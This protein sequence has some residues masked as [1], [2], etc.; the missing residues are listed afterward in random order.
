MNLRKIWLVAA[1]MVALLL[2]VSGAPSSQASAT[3]SSAPGGYFV[4]IP[5]AQVPT[6]ARLGLNPLVAVE[7]GS[8][9]WLELN[10]ADY[11]RLAS[12]GVAFT[13]VPDA[14]QV[15][16]VAYT[17]DPITDGEPTLDAGQRATTTGPALRLV[18]FVGPA[19]DVWLDAMTAAGL[20]VLQ[21]YPSNAFLTWATEA[22]AAAFAN[23]SFVRWQGVIHP[24]YK[25]DPAL[26]QM[27]GLI[28]NVDVM[29]YN[30]GRLEATLDAIT[31]LGGQILQS[32]PS[33]PDKAFYNAVV[34]LPAEAVT[35]VTQLNTVLWLGHLSPTPILDDEM[36][37]QIQ[38]GNH[39]GGTPVTGYTAHLSNLGVTGAGVVWAIVDTGVDYDHPDLG[40]NI[41][42][43]Y[44]FPGACSFAGQPGSDCAGGGHGTHVAG[45]VGGTAAAGFADANGFLYGLGVAPGYSIFAMNSL[46]A[47]AWPPA[48]GWQEHSKRAVLGGAIGGNN[49]WTTGEGTNHGYQ[50]SERTHDI[51]VLDGNFDTA[52]VAEPFIE[53]FS[54]GNSGPGANTLT[55]PKEAKNLIITASSVNFR[56]GNI[57]TISSF[58]SRGPA[59]D[60]RWVP[61]I[62]APGEQ[63]ASAR[64]DLGGSC[65]TAIPGTNNLY[66]FCSGTSM[67]SPHAAGAVVLVTEWWR[68][69]NAGADPSP[70]M[71]KALLVNGA[72]DMGTADIPNANEGWGRVN[73]TN[74]IS[75]TAMVIYFDQP[76]IFSNTG[77]QWS[78]DVGVPDPSQPL[79]IT[80]AWSDAPGAVGANPALVNNLN[81]SVVN[82]A[83]TY[84]G[85]V[86][87]GGWSATGGAADTRNNLENVYVQNPAGSA[88]ITI[89]AANI[90]GDAILYNGDPTDQSFALVCSNCALGTDF[91]L[92]A[93]PSSQNVC[94][95][96]DAVY[97]VSVGSIL[98]FVDPVALSASGNP[99]G[100]TTGFSVNPVTPPGNSVLTIGNTGAAVAGSYAIDVVGVA[101]TSTH[102]TTVQLNLFTNA[103]A[104]PS[105]TAPGNGTIN[106]GCPTFTWSDAGATSYLL[107]VDTD[108]NF[109]NIVYTANV[110]GTSHTAG[111]TLNTS[112]TYLARPGQQHLWQRQLLG[113][114]LLHHRCRAR[115]LRSRQRRQRSLRLWL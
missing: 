49:S 7:Y 107:E 87:S 73:V 50:A 110:N 48:G 101:P 40:P 22:E 103:P 20:P 114:L 26:A 38:A 115:R 1:I 43:G 59:A 34:K 82:G 111:A 42:G 57:N 62:T 35:A 100:T 6:A 80:L 95:P 55:A 63:I 36:S 52:N 89:N 92:T 41:V 67:A 12:S 75:P 17:F 81:L 85:N 47:A 29:F 33:Q 77:E 10:Q 21:Y 66:A 71:A 56:A 83:N 44:D 105:L 88:T 2:L 31:D 68:N 30:D 96:N 74:I 99:A 58:S 5:A 9:Q 32:Y 70:D 51:M 86:F 3:V 78:I 60:G 8:F 91:S 113:C 23:Q 25:P 11:D 28:E 13:S 64:N 97:N 45:I 79:R 93:T 37:S 112:S 16:V 94:A 15:Q 109:N 18:Q 27:S 24:A 76:T 65:S 90:A 46:S 39:P 106:A 14:G 84:L 102:T 53:V 72:V 98:G 61:T 54:A 4:T 108:V 19:N 69:F 104:A